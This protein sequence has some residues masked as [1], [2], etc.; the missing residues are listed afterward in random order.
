[1]KISYA[2][3]VCNEHNELNRLLSLLINAIRK[4]DEIIVQC[5]KDNT[6][7]E[8]HIVLSNYD[9]IIKVIQFPLNKDFATFK[10]NLKD[11]CTGDYIFQ[12]D[13]DEYLH[14][15]FIEHLPDI[16]E[17]NS[18]VDLYWVPRI[19]TVEGLTEDHIKKWG[20]RVDNEK[21]V[22][23]PDYQSRILKNISYIKW[24]NKVHE[25]VKGYKIE[26]LLPTDNMF[27]LLHPKTISKQE[28]QNEFYNKL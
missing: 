5:D 19:N 12:I 20:W 11:N 25:V 22:N 26:T 7:S 6:T 21:R 27:C 24:E 16:L 13:A 28:R 14:P 8:V 15:I 3:T 9:D 23:F 1:M 2:I 17:S 10:N 4:E 18:E